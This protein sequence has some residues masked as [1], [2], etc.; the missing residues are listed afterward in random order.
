MAAETGLMNVLDIDLTNYSK[1]VGRAM[2]M[3]L[4]CSAAAAEADAILLDAI[5][6]VGPPKTQAIDK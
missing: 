5:N 6:R 1:R 2:Q 4:G 3:A